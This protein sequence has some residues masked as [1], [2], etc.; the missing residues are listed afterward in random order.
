MVSIAL[1]VGLAFGAPSDW[2]G[3]EL[4]RCALEHV[5]SRNNLLGI[6]YKKQSGEKED[7]RKEYIMNKTNLY[8]ETKQEEAE[9]CK[10]SMLKQEKVHLQEEI[11]DLKQEKKHLQKEIND[12]MG[13]KKH[14]QNDLMDKREKEEAERCK[15]NMLK[16]ERV[17]LQN[18]ITDL[19]QEK[20]H[21]QKEI[22]FCMISFC[23]INHISEP[24]RTTGSYREMNRE[25]TMIGYSSGG[26]RKPR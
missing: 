24:N 6:A 18:E 3:H 17:H 22:S 5:G 19:K 12:L 2:P 7:K 4:T 11:T 23:I 25:S 9:R 1:R 26:W 13:E 16:Q 8:C 20:K 21:L 10:R 15:R 14:L